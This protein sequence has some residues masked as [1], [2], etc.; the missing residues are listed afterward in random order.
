PPE[1]P[2]GRGVREVAGLRVRP[3][4]ERRVDLREARVD[5]IDGRGEDDV[6][7]VEE[8]VPVPHRLRHDEPP[9]GELA[10]HERV[11]DL[12][13]E[14]REDDVA[15]E[16]AR[17]GIGERVVADE[18]SQAVAEHGVRR[19]TSRMRWARRSRVS[20]R[21]SSFATHSTIIPAVK[22]TT[23][24]TPR[25]SRNGAATALPASFASASS[26]SQKSTGYRSKI[27]SR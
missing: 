23:S 16:A 24:V 7:R 20:R 11:R 17:S 21:K 27:G 25:A 12:R 2:R 5:E 15:R 3:A 8:V 10:E 9:G 26:V 6:V 4:A 14:R 22:R 18:R 1:A 19:R 13:A